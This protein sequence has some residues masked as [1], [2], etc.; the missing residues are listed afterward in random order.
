MHVIFTCIAVKLIIIIIIIA[1]VYKPAQVNLKHRGSV[2]L[3]RKLKATSYS[4]I[5][6]MI[7][8]F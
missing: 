2:E 3:F 1:T 5:Y 4:H 8:E 6:I 7:I